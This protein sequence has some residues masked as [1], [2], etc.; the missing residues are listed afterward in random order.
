MHAQRQTQKPTVSLRKL[1]FPFRAA[2]AICSDIDGTDTLDKFLSIQ[3]FLCADYDTP[4]GPGLGLEIGNSFFPYALGDSFSYFSGHPRDREVI[5]SLIRAGYID[6]LHSYG[7]GASSRDDVLQALDAFERERCKLK[8]WVDHFRAPSNFGKD[9]TQGVGDV[10]GSPIYHADVTLEHGIKFVWKG[11]SSSI[12]GQDTPY[13]LSTFKRIFDRAHSAHTIA[14]I[15]RELAKAT[16]ARLGNRRFGLHRDNRL[17]QL[18]QLQDGQ[19]VYE[20]K[21]CNSHWRGLSK[22]HDSEGLAYVIRRQTLNELLAA[23]G[24]MVIYTH[25]GVGLDRPPYLPPATQAALQGLAEAYRAGDHYITTTSR[26]LTYYLNRRNMQWTYQVDEAE[27]V[28]ITIHGVADSIAGRSS[29]SIE[30]L[31]GITFYVPNRFNAR[32]FL[33]RDELNN[34]ERNPP[35]HTGKESVM[36]PRIFLSYPLSATR[37]VSHQIS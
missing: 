8:V 32:I 33:G 16:L 10:V 12:V 35:D 14:N 27:S 7:D 4:I 36:I 15:L 6:C 18:S 22:G 17:L 1:P 9:T 2:L 29:P 26:L 25:L 20:F 31:Q 37:S 5:G 34:I 28:R 21:R 23:E 30:E 3:N 13:A 24:Y 19:S 11:R